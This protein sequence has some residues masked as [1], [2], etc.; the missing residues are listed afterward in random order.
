MYACWSL[1]FIRGE[2]ACAH[3]CA[4]DETCMQ[5]S[6][7]SWTESGKEYMA[8]SSL[9]DCVLT[10]VSVK[11]A[12]NKARWGLKVQLAQPDNKGRSNHETR[13]DTKRSPHSC[14]A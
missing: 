9:T 12:G 13:H 4:Y 5:V 3:V 2:C 1:H 14:D 11:K 6:T 10:P 7:A 8:V